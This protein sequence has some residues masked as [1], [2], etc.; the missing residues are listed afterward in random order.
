MV[1]EHP[2]Q[3]EELIFRSRFQLVLKQYI[4]GLLI[5]VCVAIAVTSVLW[6]VLPHDPLV[7]WAVALVVISLLRSLYVRQTLAIFAQ[8]DFARLKQR[9]Y[10]YLVTVFLTGSIWGM[11]GSA[12]Y[13]FASLLHQGFVLV[14][15][16]AMLG[17]AVAIMY[18]LSLIYYAYALPMLLP[19]AVTL[20][21]RGNSV[22]ISISLLALL[23][24]GAMLL[25]I[26]R[27]ETTL[28]NSFRIQHE[29]T[30]LMKKLA[31]MSKSLLNIRE[32]L[33]E[34]VEQRTLELSVLNRNLNSEIEERK[35]IEE[36]LFNQKELAE[37]TLG[38]VAEGIVTTDAA[39]RILYANEKAELI[40]D[41]KLTDVY[42]Q[43]FSDAVK[44]SNEETG[45]LAKDRIE[46][47]L[48]DQAALNYPRQYLVVNH[49]NKGTAVRQS[50]APIFNKTRD[51]IGLVIVI[52][53]VTRERLHQLQ[54]SHIA[55]HD[56]LTGLH[57]RYA[58][59]VQLNR[60]DLRQA[61]G[62][63]KSAVIYIDLDHFKIVNDSCGHLAGDELL[64]QLS[65]MLVMQLD[66]QDMLARIGGDEFGAIIH[67]SDEA[68]IMNKAEQLL[69]L[70]RGFRFQWGERTFYVGASLGLVFLSDN[71]PNMQ[72]CLRYA[73]MA[74]F[75]AKE[76]GGKRIH[77]YVEEDE[78]MLAR[79]NELN[80]VTQ[81][82][83]AMEHNGL[84]LYK[85]DISRISGDMHARHYEILL[86]LR[87]SQGDIILP[88]AFISAAERYNFMQ[89]VDRWVIGQV[90]DLAE[91]GAL[92]LNGR[93]DTININLSGLSLMNEKTLE[94]ITSRLRKSPY[95]GSW[96]CF[97][98]TETTAITNFSKAIAFI[99]E[100]KK[101]DCKFALDDF[102]SGVSSLGYLKNLPVDYVKIDGAFVRDIDSDKIDYAMVESIHK[103]VSLSGKRT[104]AEYVE[105]ED[106]LR[107]LKNIGVDYAQG[108]AIAKPTRLMAEAVPQLSVSG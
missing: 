24:L 21:L 41:C 51:L 15:M 13:P 70:I 76:K 53:D 84:L 47:V 106:V 2:Q 92:W 85:Q 94:L 20:L 12:L 49:A 62:S 104:I 36:E 28:I 63:G 38:S 54:L 46:A 10:L 60:P 100:L 18:P 22:Q 108:H 67:A 98:I 35:R 91:S 52:H 56:S 87:N 78:E 33:E 95:R 69:K 66:K 86:R 97:E 73:D 3:Q 40:L 75:L 79:H 101:Y 31:K 48:R 9:Y 71:I 74:C 4:V 27:A 39:G 93:P 107:L 90:F 1:T 7:S 44:L 37:I 11:L 64:K 80:R 26:K 32:E 6:P 65:E 45:E 83:E 105:S 58:F 19:L 72:E 57:N 17:G 30:E 103:V 42:R 34:R 59:E 89:E 82:S 102:G 23:Y 43:Y 96:L 81:L 5:N 8:L 25:V 61:A 50:I 88:G 29:N 14:V 55:T 68:R 77:V 16:A 99:E